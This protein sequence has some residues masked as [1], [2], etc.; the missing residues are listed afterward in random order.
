MLY[1]KSFY[2]KWSYL[3]RQ[4]PVNMTSVGLAQARPNKIYIR[5]T[6]SKLS[7]PYVNFMYKQYRNL[8]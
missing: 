8:T 1:Y 2:S 4:N 5:P 3:S 6:K 7:G